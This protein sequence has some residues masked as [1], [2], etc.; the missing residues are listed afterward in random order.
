MRIAEAAP[1]LASRA[2]AG[3]LGR[4]WELSARK[5]RA[6]E[7]SYDPR[8]GSP[9]FTVGGAWTSRGWTE[10]TQGFQY[11]SALLQYDATGEEEFLELG[12][13]RT[14][15]RMAPHVSHVGVHDHG[16][17]NVSTYGNLLRLMNEGRLP[18]NPW[19][20]SFY[21]LALKSSGAVQAGAGRGPGI[22]GAASSTRSTGR[23]P[24]SWTRSAP[25]APWRWRTC[26]AT[27]S[28]RKTTAGCRCWSASSSTRARTA[29]L[30]RS[31]TA[32]AAT[33]TTCPAG[34][35]TSP[36]F[37]LTDGRYRCPNSQQG[38]S[39]FSTWTRGLAWAI[40]G[41]AEQVEFLDGLA[42][43]EPGAAGSRQ[44][45]LAFMRRALQVTCDF[46]LDNTA[47]DGI[48]YWDT[49]APG[50][51]RL[52]DWRGR[53]AD[54]YNDAEPVDSSA[55]AIACQ[56]L[57]RL[58]R[59]LAGR[60]DPRSGRYL[61]AGL[62]VLARLLEEPYLSVRADHQGLLLHSV[63]HRPNGWDHVPPGR[64]V[65][66]GESSMWGDYHL[67]EA[68]LYAQRLERGPY[69]VFWRG[70]AAHD[71][72]RPGPN[73]RAHLPG[74]APDPEPGRRRLADPGPELLHGVRDPGAPRRAGALAQPGAGRGLLRDA[75][76]RRGLPRGG[77]GHP[78]GGPGGVHPAAGLPPAHQHRG[79]AP[80][81]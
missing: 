29:R 70:E 33:S 79:G 16:F 8:Q 40:L 81:A 2:L 54:P 41:F 24:C 47:S 67:R 32:R 20:R 11:G 5:I 9:V 14:V 48:P 13:R 23:T 46:Y 50:L 30:F 58:G 53:P 77:A 45:A 1:A 51:V 12:R 35:P 18:E 17:N 19:E 15:E 4:M 22:G 26:W 63:Y 69:L 6:A 74:A 42:D 10:W 34:S 3:R 72:R 71:H 37:N 64:A 60:G 49:G 36:I 28:W 62:A 80:G 78:H 75:G 27:S 61:S 38:Y 65:P 55:A 68:A 31:T 57:M 59:D 73:R 7:R 43:W 76:H 21:E 66:C 44:D 39:P 52:G 25:C 56:G